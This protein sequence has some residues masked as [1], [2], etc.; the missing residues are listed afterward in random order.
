M[1]HNSQ[2]LQPTE[3]EYDITAT[4]LQGQALA[5]QYVG[6]L[7]EKASKIEKTDVLRQLLDNVTKV[8]GRDGVPM[9]RLGCTWAGNV[10]MAFTTELAL[11][12]LLAKSAIEPPRTHDLL[13]LYKR[14][15]PETQKKLESVF[16]LPIKERKVVGVDSLNQLLA[17]HKD[18]FAGWRYLDKD[19]ENLKAGHHDLQFAVWAILEVYSAT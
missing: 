16:K 14:L 4:R 6:F 19:L 7:L 2:I 10:I 18:D 11:K 8:D 17:V 5:M 3:N 13:V 9:A 12:A 1:N 15:S